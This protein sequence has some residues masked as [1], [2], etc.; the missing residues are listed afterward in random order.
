MP[1]FTLQFTRAIVHS[2]A[3]DKCIMACI[4]YYSNLQSIFTALKILCALPIHPSLPYPHFVTPSIV[5]PFLECHVVE[6]V[7]NLF[8]WLLSVSKMHLFPLSLFMA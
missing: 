5:L 8:R 1:S 6:T 7:C 2:V 3:L 4:N